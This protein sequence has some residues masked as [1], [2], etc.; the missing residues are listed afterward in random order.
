MR[1]ELNKAKQ[2]DPKKNVAVKALAK[3]RSHKVKVDADRL[4][5]RRRS[6]SIYDLKYLLAKGYK[7][8]RLLGI[9]GKREGYL[10]KP[11]QNESKEHF[12][13]IF[14]IAEYLKSKFKNVELYQ[15]LKPDIIFERKGKSYAVEVE[16]GSLYLKARDR[17]TEKVKQLREN[18]GERYCFVVTNEDF[19]LIYNR[20]GKTFT[21]TTFLKQFQKWLKKH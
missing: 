6:L 12:F 20:L 1:Q 13:L 14:N 9:N 17:L 8:A 15:T 3:Q 4:F 7:E 19:A 2:M 21:R 10:I 5:F 18:F 11:R 16:T